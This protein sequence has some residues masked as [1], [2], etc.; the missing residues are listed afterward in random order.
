MFLYYRST[1]QMHVWCWQTS[2]ART[3][4]PKTP[5]TS[6]EWFRSKI[7]PMI[8]ESSFNLCSTIIRLVRV[9]NRNTKILIVCYVSCFNLLKINFME[10]LAYDYNLF[11]VTILWPFSGVSA[12]HPQLE[13]ETRRRRDLRV[14]TKTRF[15]CPIVPSPGFLHND[16]QFIRYEVF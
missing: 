5:P 11:I 10:K 16:G 7:I 6:C 14:R 9:S 4:T 12:K 15:Y 2:T 1:R 3:P 13:L 8:L